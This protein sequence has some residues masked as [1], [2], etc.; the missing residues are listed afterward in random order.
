MPNESSA[1]VQVDGAQIAY[2]RVGN[3]L[4]LLVL[5]GFAGT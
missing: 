3:G 2:R 5:N 1:T 4:P